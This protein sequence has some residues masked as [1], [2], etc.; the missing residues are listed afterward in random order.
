WRQR[1]L[2]YRTVAD[3]LRQA[4]IR[5]WTGRSRPSS[6]PRPAGR[7]DENWTD[8]NTRTSMRQVPL[9]NAVAQPVNVQIA[10]ALINELEITAQQRLRRQAA[11]VQKRMYRRLQNAE[12][13]LLRLLIVACV[14]YL[15]MQ[16][17][18]F[19]LGPLRHYFEESRLEEH[20]G[21]TRRL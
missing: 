17:P 12:A 5:M 10:I 18:E 13:G 1:W 3:Q 14:A 2:E 4:R 16:A 8:L 19:D 9:I 15:V 20:H 11:T 6:A 21:W 7:A